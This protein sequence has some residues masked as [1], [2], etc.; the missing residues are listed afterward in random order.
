MPQKRHVLSDRTHNSLQK[1]GSPVFTSQGAVDTELG[2]NPRN[3]KSLAQCDTGCLG[4]NVPVEGCSSAVERFVHIEEV[5]GS[6][7]PSPT[8]LLPLLT[9][10]V[11]SRFWSKVSR[12]DPRTCWEWTASKKNSRDCYGHFKIASY[13]TVTASRVAYAI[14][15]GEEPG[16]LSVLH[17]CDNPACCNPAHLYLGTTKDNTRDMVSRGRA[18]NGFRKGSSNG[19]NKLDARA[20]YIITRCIRRGLTNTEIAARFGVHH[21]TISLIRR[22]KK[23]THLLERLSDDRRTA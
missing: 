23:W 21:S 1:G 22:G 9:P 14:A 13:K 18:R 11:I 20:V 8:V 12:G 19:A 7:P 10:A 6:T 2:S 5:G 17:T 3:I 4:T 16:R 15:Y